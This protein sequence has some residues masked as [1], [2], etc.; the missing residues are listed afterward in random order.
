MDDTGNVAQ[1]DGAAELNNAEDYS[2]W[3]RGK[4]ERSVA[5]VLSGKSRLYSLDEVRSLVA[6]LQRRHR[7]ECER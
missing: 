2:V 7:A 1:P 3:L 5:G 4:V 6:D